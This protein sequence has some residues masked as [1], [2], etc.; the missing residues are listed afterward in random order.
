[1]AGRDIIIGSHSYFDA[2]LPH[3][4]TV[5]DEIAVA[6]AKGQ[7]PILVGA[8]NDYLGY[9]TVADSVRETSRNAVAELNQNGI[10]ATVMLTGDNEATARMHCATGGR[11]PMCAPICCRSRRWTQSRRCSQYG[12]VAMVG[13]GVNDAPALATATVGIAMG[14]GTAQAME[15]ADIALMGNDLSKLPFALN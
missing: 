5:C 8:G 11:R 4:K 10:E 15:T 12:S 6:S 14:A 2:T 1:M 13:D 7:T 3:D 9:I